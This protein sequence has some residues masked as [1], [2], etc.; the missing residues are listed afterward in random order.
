MHFN[1]RRLRL[2]GRLIAENKWYFLGAALCTLL[3]VAADYM[4]PLLLAETLDHYLSGLPSQLPGFVNAWVERLGGADYMAHHLWLVGLMLVGLSLMGGLFNF[5]KGRWQSIAGENAARELR[6]RLYDHIQRLP[7]SYHVKAE[8]GDLVQRCT[9][10]VDTVRKFL[11]NQLMA[12]LSALLM[13]TLAL[14]VLF[15]RNARLA[16]Y[17]MIMVPGLFLF[18]YLFFK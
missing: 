1:T 7:F 12:I 9:S 16:A 18:A 11:I 3:S 8:T 4:T 2:M 10:D 5:A 15:G 17:S 6:Q 13:I 14:I